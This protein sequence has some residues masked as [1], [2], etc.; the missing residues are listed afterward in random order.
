MAERDEA[1]VTCKKCEHGFK[2]DLSTSSPWLCPACGAKNPNLKRHVRSV[3][4]VFIL[5][6]IVLVVVLLSHVKAN[7]IDLEAAIY[8][9]NAV[10]LLTAIIVIYRRCT[11]WSS[12]ATHVLMWLPV[13]FGSMWHVV[14]PL[15]NA[16]RVAI[17]YL[18]VYVAVALYLVALTRR[19]RQCRDS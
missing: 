3:A 2:P 7:G 18:A 14:L 9:A 8:V 6:F 19:A 13:I 11:S 12:P 16:G 10:L 5:W 4:D 15:I 17:P 1:R